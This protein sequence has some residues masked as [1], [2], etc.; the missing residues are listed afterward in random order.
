MPPHHFCRKL[1]CASPGQEELL[2]H[3]TLLTSN[4][5]TIP[6]PKLGT[7]GTSSEYSPLFPLLAHLQINMLSV[8]ILHALWHCLPMTGV[9]GETFSI[10][11]LY[12]LILQFMLFPICCALGRKIKHR[13]LNFLQESSFL[14]FPYN[15]RLIAIQQNL[16]VYSLC[17]ILGFAYIS[18]IS[19]NGAGKHVHKSSHREMK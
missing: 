16:P 11:L 12:I 15:F 1:G 19:V 18:L 10:V 17:A 3:I 13:I 6:V 5:S 4:P 9:Q 8:N 7:Y 14:C 2:S